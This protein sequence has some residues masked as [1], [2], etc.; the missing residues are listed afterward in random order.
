RR[1]VEE[2]RAAGRDRPEEGEVGDL[3]LH[4]LDWVER[5]GQR[6]GHARAGRVRRA[7]VGAGRE[8]G[9]QGQRSHAGNSV[10]AGRR[11][12]T[13]VLYLIPG[14]WGWGRG[15]GGVSVTGGFGGVGAP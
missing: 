13:P 4:P 1:L 7:R 10:G 8:Q 5:P 9:G 15:G 12:R 6:Y 11:G 3:G 2:R 14:G